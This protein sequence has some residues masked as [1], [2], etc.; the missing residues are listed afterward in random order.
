MQ[1]I[2]SRSCNLCIFFI[3][4]PIGVFTLVFFKVLRYFTD[5]NIWLTKKKF[6]E[7]KLEIIHVI[8]SLS[9]MLKIIFS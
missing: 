6:E 8:F 9:R 5:D 4:R 1:K 2:G 3:Y 7:S